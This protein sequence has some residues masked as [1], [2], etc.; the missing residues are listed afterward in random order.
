MMG[1]TSAG[2]L[3]VISLAGVCALALAGCGSGVGGSSAPQVK[4]TDGVVIGVNSNGMHEFLGIPYA[5]PPIGSLRW[6]APQPVHPWS[7]ALHADRFAKF[8]PQTASGFG[9][10]S[11][12]EDCLYLN[13][14]APR[15]A[16]ASTTDP[17]MVWFP[18]GAMIEGESNTY[19]PAPLVIHGVVVVTI[20][21][22]LGVLGFLATPALSAASPSGASGDYGLMDQQA[23]LT[24][25][26]QNIASFGGD[27]NNVT[28]FGQSA[29]GLSVLSQLVSPAS[30]QQNL[31][32]KAIIES[33]S[34]DGV[35]GLP[36]LAEAQSA[37]APFITAVGCTGAGQNN[38]QI[39]TCL[40][41]LSV[42]EILAKSST[43]ETT[44]GF[45]PNTGTTILP[46]GINTSLDNGNFYHVPVIEGNNRNEWRWFEGE[47][48]LARGAPLSAADYPAGVQATVALVYPGTTSTA[49]QQV[50]TQYPL[51]SFSSPD[52]ALS[53]V[54][55]DAIFSCPGLTQI[56]N[57]SKYTTTYAYEFNDPDAP[58]VFLPPVTFAY[59][60]A[61]ASELQYLFDLLAPATP[62]ALDPSQVALSNDMTSY[63]TQFATTGNPSSSSGALPM[64][65]QF[66]NGSTYLSLQP[67]TPIAITTFSSEHKCNFWATFRA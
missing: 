21:Y 43:I 57:L 18:G 38:A 67:T 30:K 14:F 63:W 29:G 46:N 41:S 47:E 7:T 55:T 22:R 31:F 23:A 42:S 15:N 8:C 5:A 52:T 11:T 6:E 3:S 17:V 34:Y 66:T 61:H 27:P 25:V 12:S 1:T 48:Q 16:S 2:R 58:Q 51:T 54:G 36:T 33:G 35:A 49:A 53:A 28:V 56:T 13:V 19:N 40:R 37:D 39:V 62:V 45:V 10:A 60:S 20:N 26:K 50:A 65:P 4:T 32:Q 59:R 64:W 24:W 9:V 44:A